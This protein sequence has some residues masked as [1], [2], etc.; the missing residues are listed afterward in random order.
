MTG[1]CKSKIK[2][3]TRAVQQDPILIN[4]TI[5][6]PIY[7]WYLMEKLNYTIGKYMNT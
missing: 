6:N 5:D 4:A 3:L 2:A 1:N 7:Q